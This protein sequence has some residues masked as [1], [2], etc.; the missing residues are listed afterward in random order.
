MWMVAVSAPDMSVKDVAEYLGV[1]TRTVYTMMADGRLQA[2]KCGCR[3]VRF[4]RSEIDAAMTPV[5]AVTE[6]MANIPP[7]TQSRGRRRRDG[8]D[9]A[10]TPVDAATEPMANVPP[11]TQSRG[12]K[13][14]DRDVSKEGRRR[15]A[16]IDA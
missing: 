6:P 9:A 5:A 14:R 13:P 8:I 7:P 16:E 2:Y 3:L 10:M 12:R 1:T 15:R 11:K 4:R